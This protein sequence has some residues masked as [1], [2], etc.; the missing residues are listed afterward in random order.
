MDY[1]QWLTLNPLRE[2]RIREGKTLAETATLLD[3]GIS[4]LERWERGTVPNRESLIK[5]TAVTG[6]TAQ[7]IS[8]WKALRIPAWEELPSL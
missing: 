8:D 6:V 1:R 4:T 5:V 3:T 2:W 7:Q